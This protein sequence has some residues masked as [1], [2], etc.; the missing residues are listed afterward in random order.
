MAFDRS[1]AQWLARYV[2]DTERNF[3]VSKFGV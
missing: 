2:R 3:K 1:V